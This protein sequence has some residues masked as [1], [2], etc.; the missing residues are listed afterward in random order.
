MVIC[1]KRGADLR[2]AQL[3]PLP[4]AVSYLASVR[5]RLVLL[6]WYRLTQVVLDKRPLNGCV[7]AGVFFFALIAVSIATD[8]GAGTQQREKNAF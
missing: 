7:C 8:S 6:F 3:I 1:L 4:L 2:M 5:S